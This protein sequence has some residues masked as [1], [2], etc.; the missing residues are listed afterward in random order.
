[1]EAEKYNET[2]FDSLE[3][4]KIYAQRIFN[5]FMENGLPMQINT[6]KQIIEEAR[7]DLKNGENL[8]KIFRS[9]F[10]DIFSMLLTVYT[11]FEHGEFYNQMITDLTTVDSTNKQDILSIGSNSNFPNNLMTCGSI[12]PMK[13]YYNALDRITYAVG[14][15]EKIFDEQ[16]VSKRVFMN[17]HRTIRRMII[18]FCEQRLKLEFPESQMNLRQS[19]LTDTEKSSVNSRNSILST[20]SNISQSNSNSSGSNVGRRKDEL[21]LF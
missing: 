7:N 4:K 13:A 20:L 12:Y 2:K 17:R 5:T 16:M 6:K 10:M 3:A 11:E 9:T 15:I 8:D 1:M 14:N 19:L 18:N 21:E